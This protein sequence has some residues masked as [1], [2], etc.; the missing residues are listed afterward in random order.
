MSN[1]NQGII[2]AILVGGVILLFNIQQVLKQILTE[3]KE[4]GVDK[5]KNREP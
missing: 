2:F 4:T 3:I 5:R 1:L